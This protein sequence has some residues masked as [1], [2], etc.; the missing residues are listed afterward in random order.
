MATAVF[1]ALAGVLFKGPF[2][3]ALAF[4]QPVIYSGVCSLPRAN[5]TNPIR[6]GNNVATQRRP[7]RLL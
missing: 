1:P 2:S 6:S 3:D 4:L 5:R 7:L